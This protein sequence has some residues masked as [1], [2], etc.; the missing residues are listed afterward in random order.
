MQIKRFEDTLDSEF[1]GRSARKVVPTPKGEHLLSYAR[2]MLALNDEA[3]GL[4][5]R[6]V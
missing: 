2:R 5:T 4:L 6:K 3:F 1:L